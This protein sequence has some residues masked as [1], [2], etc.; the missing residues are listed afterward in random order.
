MSLRIL[1][2]SD[3]SRERA[4]ARA[5]EDIQR[6]LAYSAERSRVTLDSDVI[7]AAVFVRRFAPKELDA[8]AEAKLWSVLNTLTSAV[9]PVTASS[10]RDMEALGYDEVKSRRT[11]PTAHAAVRQARWWLAGTFMGVLVV[12]IYAV[13]GTS[14]LSEISRLDK[15]A[16]SVANQIGD[17]KA[18]SGPEGPG[19][20]LDLFTARQMDLAAKLGAE[21]GLLEAWNRPWR[22]VTLSPVWNGVGETLLTGDAMRDQQI[23]TE[24]PIQAA[25]AAVSALSVYVL[26]LLY[27]LLGASAFVLRR[28]A[29]Q[30]DSSTFSAVSIHRH[31]IRRVLGMVFGP[32]VV[33][34][35]GPTE[36]LTRL[37]PLSTVALA[38]VA[39]Y[40][41]EV[42]FALFDYWIE[43]LRNALKPVGNASAAPIADS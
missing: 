39:G 24:V 42:V 33:L 22:G 32:T 2:E 40:G 14:I 4:I 41:V 27:G 36:G 30:I 9:F 10:L 38:F 35:V 20:N 37:I 1:H 6:L 8:A 23:A 5:Q 29:D 25:Q 7:E 11:I 26:P 43:K 28:V 12:Q 13:V 16:E 17:L 18:K 19:V 15:E 31:R 34:L 21:Q 3:A